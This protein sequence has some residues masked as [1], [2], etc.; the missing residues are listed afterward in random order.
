[1]KKV[2]VIKAHEVEVQPFSLDDFTRDDEKQNMTGN[3]SKKEL[4]QLAED[5]GLSYNEA[6]IMFAKKLLNAYLLGK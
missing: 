2:E 6:Q 3:I 4:K 5:I 1:M